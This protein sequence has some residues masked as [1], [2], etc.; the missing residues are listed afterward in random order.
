MAS[1]NKSEISKGQYARI[2]IFKV[3]AWTLVKVAWRMWLDLFRFMVMQAP[4]VYL[5]PLDYTFLSLHELY[6]SGSQTNTSLSFS[7]LYLHCAIWVRIILQRGKMLHHKQQPVFSGL[8]KAGMGVYMFLK[9]SLHMICS[10][11]C[12]QVWHTKVTWQFDCISDTHSFTT[13]VS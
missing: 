4:P 8:C 3:S 2:L 9:R 13:F 1:L 6:M 12:N 7:H 10:V 5:Q 11:F